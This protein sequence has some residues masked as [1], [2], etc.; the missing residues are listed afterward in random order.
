[1]ILKNKREFE[2]AKE[3]LAKLVD[4]HQYEQM[5]APGTKLVPST[6]IMHLAA[7]IEKYE[8]EGPPPEEKPR[9]MWNNNYGNMGSFSTANLANDDFEEFEDL[10]DL[11]MEFEI[12]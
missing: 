3:K 2:E 10:G 8:K 11:D 7:A 9:N 1:M 6:E 12:I 5:L 4:R